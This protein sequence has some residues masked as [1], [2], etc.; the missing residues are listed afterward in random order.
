MCR[1][2]LWGEYGPGPEPTLELTS[3]SLPDEV[4]EM[5]DTA[6]GDCDACS[7]W[8]RA[9]TYDMGE[10][11]LATLEDVLLAVL[12]RQESPR[13][14][15]NLGERD[16]GVMLGDLDWH[17]LDGLVDAVADYVGVPG[18]KVGELNRSW[19]VAAGAEAWESIWV[20][21]FDNG[22][23]VAVSVTDYET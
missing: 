15:S 3:R 19:Y 1:E 18:Y 22:W 17:G 6:S 2:K 14:W 20:L 7:L 9:Y 13:E 12:D 21:H 11:G 8:A 10:N 4:E 16:A 23:I 5:V